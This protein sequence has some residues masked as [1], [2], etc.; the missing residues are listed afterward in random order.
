MNLGTFTDVVKIDR[1]A[2]T[3]ISRYNFDYHLTDGT[4]RF[5]AFYQGRAVSESENDSYYTTTSGD[6]GKLDL[7]SYKFYKTPYLW[8]VI[9]VANK[10][11]NP[12][13]VPVGTRLRIPALDTVQ[14]EL[15]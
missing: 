3:A 5:L 15:M 8:W 12:L 7:I 10:V 6:E 13:R 14:K 1:P 11:L 2:R 9:A 4:F